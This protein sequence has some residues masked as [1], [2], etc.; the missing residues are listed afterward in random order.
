MVIA[1]HRVFGCCFIIKDLSV[2]SLKGFIGN[3]QKAKAESSEKYWNFGWRHDQLKVI[4]F[5]LEKRQ[6]FADSFLVSRSPAAKTVDEFK[7]EEI[8]K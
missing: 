4:N 7:K 1:E 6:I 3:K 2:V 5:P 8:N